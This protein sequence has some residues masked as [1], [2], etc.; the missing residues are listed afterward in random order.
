MI[1]LKANKD[2]VKA[3][4]AATTLIKY[5]SR[6]KDCSKCVFYTQ[7]VIDDGIFKGCSINRPFSYVEIKE[8]NE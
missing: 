7:Y 4:D 6:Y 3:L 5:C 2:T 8:D 1:F